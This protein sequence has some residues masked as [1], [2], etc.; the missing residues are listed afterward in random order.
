MHG[1]LWWILVGLVAGWVTGKLMKGGGYGVL[2]DIVIGIAGAIIGGWAMSLA[3]FASSG[4]FIYTVVVA[5]LGAMLLT[6]LVRKLK[7]A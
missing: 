6:W 1:L 3:G 4:G 7:K 2:M 5:I